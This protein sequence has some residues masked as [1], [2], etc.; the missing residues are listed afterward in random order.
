MKG[1]K[2]MKK[3]NKK[4]II[5]LLEKRFDCDYR[6]YTFSDLHC[7]HKYEDIFDFVN[8]EVTISYVKEFGNHWM[9]ATDMFEGTYCITTDTIEYL[10]G[11]TNNPWEHVYNL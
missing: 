11:L 8:F 6:K 5:D 10:S 9:K 1:E 7:H 3:S 4:A 2:Q